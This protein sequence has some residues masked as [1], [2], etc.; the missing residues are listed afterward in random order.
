MN[1][2]RG[3]IDR[4]AQPGSAGKTITPHPHRGADL[5][6]WLDG[7]LGIVSALRVRVHLAFCAGCREEVKWLRRL[8]EDMRDLEK[9]VPA[10]HLRARILAA[11][12]DMPPVRRIYYTGS[13]TRRS[14]VVVAAASACVVIAG[15]GFAIGVSKSAATNGPPTVRH[16]VA[17]VPEASADT[18]RSIAVS[19]S[20]PPRDPTS[21]AA[22]RLFAQM[23]Q[24]KA[25]KA[26]RE[27]GRNSARWHAM[28]TR[29]QTAAHQ[30]HE[31]A[32]R[33]RILVADRSD[34]ERAMVEWARAVGGTGTV[35]VTPAA[36]AGV[37]PTVAGAENVPQVAPVP[38]SNV[39]V[40]TLRVPLKRLTTLGTVLERCS[41]IPLGAAKLRA[42]EVVSIHGAPLLSASPRPTRVL[43]EQVDANDQA[44]GRD[45]EA[46]MVTVQVEVLDVD[47]ILQ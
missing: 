16:L 44:A 13:R 32:G 10:P 5:K 43:P 6:A 37:A 14:G 18:E 25:E 21:E 41:V 45:N 26:A 4:S 2:R 15:I 24:T 46:P 39:R 40:T 9:A 3:D 31:P 7:E 20:L 19:P 35:A 28:L 42:T 1:F 27:Q 22:D 38:A 36:P 8:G 17:T 30:G 47:A 11:L 23:M 29:I 33:L 34:V 12:P